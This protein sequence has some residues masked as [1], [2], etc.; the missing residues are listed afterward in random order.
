MPNTVSPITMQAVRESG[1]VPGSEF[2]LEVE[3]V[4]KEFPGV[5]ALD[6]VRL[7][8]KRGTV[9]ALMGENGAGKSTLMK[10][11]A[12]IYTP[13]TGTFKL[14]GQNIRLKS[15]LDALENGIAMI[16]QELNLMGTMTV[17]ENIWIRREP[18][19]RFGL[20]DHGKMRRMTEELFRRLDI[21]IDP[22]IKIGKLSVANRQMVEIAKAVSFNSDVLIMDEP[23]SALTEKEVTHL[24]KIIRALKAEGKGII[25]ITHKM[26]ELFD[27][28]DEVSVFRDGHYIA[29][30]AATEVTRDEI[31]RMM[32]GREITQ[33]FPKETV[34]IGD[35]VLSVRGLTLNKVFRDVSFDVRAGEIL[36]LA[37][38]VGSG[39]SNVAETIFGVTPASSGTIHINGKQVNI[40]S[41]AVAMRHGMA[42]L[43]EDRKDT[44]CFLL[45]DIQD[46]TQ[47][48]VLQNRY[49]NFG[50]V[51]QSKLS[52]DAAT[53]ANRLRVRTPDM[54]EPIV[55]LSGGNQ[56]KVL[57][58]RWLLTNPKIL[59]LDEPTRGIDVGA[60]AEIHRL[61]SQLAGQG[62]AVIMISSEMPEVLGMSDRIMVLHEG[63]MTGILDR[64]DAD[65]VKI[66]ELAS[67]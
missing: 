59:I 42:F 6:N 12:G 3:D 38:L 19:N 33:M 40:S 46:N 35:V 57:I 7:T 14:R 26:N 13:D 50:F 5:V 67:H 41:P 62:V 29:T 49:V 16:H 54:H 10:I 2:L 52:K 15:P 22:E 32:V 58:A 31:I 36:G 17:A 37:G 24:F 28:A 60:K 23:T 61:I 47:M 55:N 8:L 4:R 45:L 25:Y 53:M 34:P 39:R 30:K 1:A 64:K 56:Q 66:M 44:G 20:I 9:H 18:K 65:Q 11:L 63:R 48:A 43:T 51:Q 21:D 27:I